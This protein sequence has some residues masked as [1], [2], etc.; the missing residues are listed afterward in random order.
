MAGEVRSVVLNR[1]LSGGFG[2]SILGGSGSELPPV[3][4]DIVD[5]SPASDSGEV[6]VGG[7]GL[8]RGKRGAPEFCRRSFL[9]FD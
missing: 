6:S 2:F 8:L 9:I 5:G 7:A 4:Y 1:S 3:V